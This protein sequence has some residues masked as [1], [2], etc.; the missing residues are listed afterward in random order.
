M[1]EVNEQATDLDTIDIGD[2]RKTAKIL[3]LATQRTWTKEEY[4]NGIKEFQNRTSMQVAFDAN[5]PAAGY[6]RVVI[7]RDPTPKAPNSPVPVSVN[8]RLLHIPRGIEVD[9]P[10]EFVE[11]LDN[12][13]SKVLVEV[14][15]NNE[16]S[17]YIEQ[18]QQSY[19]FQVKA[20]TPGVANKRADTRTAAYKQRK[21]FFDSIGRWPTHGE[22]QEWMKSRMNK[23]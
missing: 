3:G 11:A 1:S 21:D 17:T 15:G 18:T 4:I 22:L 2:L 12:A 13:R 16:R 9:V 14:E 10:T 7:H 8:G 23:V 19:P 5:A 6:S 20:V